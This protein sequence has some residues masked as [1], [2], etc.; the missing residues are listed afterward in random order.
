VLTN[1]PYA[2][3]LDA[4]FVED[5]G[6]YEFPV[7]IDDL[8]APGLGGRLPQALDVIRANADN[9]AI[10]VLLVHTDDPATKVPAE[11]A[12][13]AQL[14]AD[15]RALDMESFAKFWRARDHL[16]WRVAPGAIPRE[17]LLHVRADET[18]A[19]LT[20]EFGRALAAVGGQAAMLAD[21]HRVVLPALQPGDEVTLHIRYAF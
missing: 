12:L 18:V 5:S 6:L 20:F 19:G 14:P 11:E 1:F 13:L 16:Q 7:T 2:L 15:V 8:E 17:I 3:P 4:G 21:H 9:G 10:S